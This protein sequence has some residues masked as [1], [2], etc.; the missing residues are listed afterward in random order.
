MI[1]FNNFN[2]RKYQ[3]LSQKLKKRQKIFSNMQFLRNTFKRS[4]L[5]VLYVNGI[6]DDNK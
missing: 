3:K 4:R 5:P 1:T 6:I 2:G